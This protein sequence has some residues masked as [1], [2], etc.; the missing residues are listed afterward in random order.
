[1][2][3]K[4]YQEDVQFDVNRDEIILFILTEAKQSINF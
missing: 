1:M 3:I 2:K 4:K